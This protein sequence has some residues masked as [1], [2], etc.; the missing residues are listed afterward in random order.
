MLRRRRA[1]SGLDAWAAGKSSACGDCG[2]GTG[3]GKASVDDM[4]AVPR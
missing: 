4:V 2:S 3:V 1:R